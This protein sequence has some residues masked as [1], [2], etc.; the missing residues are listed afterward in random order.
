MST[1]AQMTR[2]ELK[3]LIDESVEEKILELIG[4]PDEL[5]DVMGQLPPEAIKSE[6]M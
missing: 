1:I 4:D 6:S 2:N 5:R 3:A